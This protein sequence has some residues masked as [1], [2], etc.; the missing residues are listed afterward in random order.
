MPIPCLIAVNK[1]INSPRYASLPGIMKAKKKQIKTYSLADLGL[2][3]EGPTL[4]DSDY[5][6]PPERQAGAGL[7][8]TARSDRAAQRYCAARRWQGTPSAQR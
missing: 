7:R 1:G 2:A 5:Q 4:K 3:G 6:L 8:P